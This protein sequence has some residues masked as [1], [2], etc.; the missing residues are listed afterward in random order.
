MKRRTFLNMA[1]SSAVLIKSSPV[2]AGEQLEKNAESMPRKD[3]T[4]HT[5]PYSKP[6]GMYP[7]P[8][9]IYDSLRLHFGSALLNRHNLFLGFDD[10]LIAHG[11]A[12]EPIGK[13]Q[14]IDFYSAVFSE[15][16]DF[17]LVDDALLIAGDMGAHR[18]HALGT[19]KGGKHPSGK[20]IMFRGQTIY[21]VNKY[22]R[23]TWRVSNHD[24]GFRES[25]IEYSKHNSL[26][27]GYRSWAPSADAAQQKIE[28][29][30]EGPLAEMWVRDKVARLM[31]AASDPAQR[32][33]YWD[34][35]HDDARV[36][37]VGKAGPLDSSSLSELKND[38]NTLWAAM[39]DL[40]Y[41]TAELI[42]CEDYAIQQWF[43]VGHHTAANWLGE[44]A[45]GQQQILSA[46][47]VYRFDSDYKIVEQWINNGS[48]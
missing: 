42:V 30:S 23:V 34:F 11:M 3:N 22:G 9:F 48:D 40:N 31:I 2:F 8:E 4:M 46:Q 24:H 45:N 36:Y 33:N 20:Q 43:A 39:P 15:F 7:Q 25:Q 16:P 44:T 14:L 19:H 26:K 21:R 27:E 37:G 1:A 13:E 47:T 17:R 38:N 35:Y 32:D 41:V 6:A 18:Y 29:R 28:R 12:P 10:D 5:F